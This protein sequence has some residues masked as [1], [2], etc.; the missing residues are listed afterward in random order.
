MFPTEKNGADTDF[1]CRSRRRWHCVDRF[2]AAAPAAAASSSSLVFAYRRTPLVAFGSRGFSPSTEKHGGRWRLAR[3]RPRLRT[4]MRRDPRVRVFIA[5][6]SARNAVVLVFFTALPSAVYD[7]FFRCRRCQR[8]FSLSS[9]LTEN[10]FFFLSC[11]LFIFHVFSGFS[12]LCPRSPR[13]TVHR[14][15]ENRYTHTHTG[16]ATQLCC[17]Y[18]VRK[19]EENACLVHSFQSDDNTVNEN[20]T[21][22]DYSTVFFTFSVSRF[23]TFNFVVFHQAGGKAGKDSGKSKAKAVSRSARAGLQVNKIFR[24][25]FLFFFYFL[26]W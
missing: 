25:Y 10:F 22:C 6:N 24:F 17:C 4:Q 26:S 12:I 16:D 5:P 21:R 8:F 9:R 19:T 14:K 7:H 13:F 20:G 2:P 1:F 15:F 11:F 18:P 3:A 23:C